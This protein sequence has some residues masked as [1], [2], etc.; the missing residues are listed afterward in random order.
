MCDSPTR[1]TAVDLDEVEVSRSGI[2][3]KAP[4]WNALP[5]SRILLREDQPLVDH[6]RQ[7]F[8]LGL[9]TEIPVLLCC[10]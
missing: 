4:R 9:E 6:Q 3:Q 1:N 8:T 7:G 5:R 2:V 10:H